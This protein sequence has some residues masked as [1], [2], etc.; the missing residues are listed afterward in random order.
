MPEKSTSR[1]QFLKEGALVG[2][3]L[4]AGMLSCA[5]SLR[6]ITPQGRDGRIVVDT[7]SIE[8]FRE[9]G[10]AV[11]VNNG[12]SED[13]VI[14]VRTT[15]TEYRAFSS[16]CPHLGCNVRKNR[17]GFRCP[18]HGSAFDLSGK[19]VTGPANEDLPSYDVEIDGDSVSIRI[20]S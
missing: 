5:A 18:C 4:S 11:L 16:V 12:E 2:A 19:V 6:T 10:A 9:V 17:F 8:E 14:L 1:R 3:G 13:P 20:S 7:S 15:D